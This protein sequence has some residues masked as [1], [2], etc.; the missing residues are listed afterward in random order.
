MNTLNLPPV[1]TTEPRR[2]NNKNLTTALVVLLSVATV[3]ILTALFA[4]ASKFRPN[5]NTSS[6]SDMIITEPETQAETEPETE[7]APPP[8]AAVTE[9]TSASQTTVTTTVTTTIVT[10]VTTTLPVMITPSGFP[11]R[12]SLVDDGLVTDIVDNQGMYGSCFAF[13]WLGAYENRLLA[14]GKY[15]DLS[16]WAFYKSFKRVYRDAD[17]TND[18]ASLAN[19]HTAVVPESEAPY[20]EDFGEYEVPYNIEDKSLYRLSDVYFI[21]GVG[22]NTKESVTRRAKDYLTRGYALVT[23]VY[24]D[25][26]EMRYTDNY[27]G[28]WY[29]SENIHRQNKFIN[30]AVLIVGWDDNYSRNNFIDTPNHDGAWLVKNSWGT[31]FGDDGYYWL[32]YDDEMFL[33]SEM[34]AVDITDASLCNTVQSYWDYGWEYSYYNQHSNTALY[35]IP[36]KSVYQACVYTAP[37]DMDITAV[38][39][40]TVADNISYKVFI[41]DSL[42]NFR[43]NFY[44]VAAGTEE[45]CGFHLVPTNKYHVSAGETYTVVVYM[46]GAKDEYLVAQDS[47]YANDLP[48]A[49]PAAAGTCFVSA[50]G[51]DW[52]D[53]IYYD[54]KSSA[55]YSFVMPLCIS[56]YGK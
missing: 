19:F 13:A 36:Q 46:E 35:G 21:S 27:N 44:S 24:Y 30:H 52:N 6:G 10:S 38:S 9:T 17:R 7:T 8:T 18:I 12:Y 41:T 43:T 47:P 39:F 50:D 40:F 37:K 42:D 28:A 22:E 55:G 29:V 31:Y 11:T 20:P 49:E 23:S 4:T 34:V 56:A 53:V 32:S 5:R 2:R 26:G 54:M 45:T 48:V 3:L 33:F 1:K 51:S 25:N 14:D 16:E 15:E